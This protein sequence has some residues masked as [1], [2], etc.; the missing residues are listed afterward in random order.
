MQMMETIGLYN[1][2]KA[3]DAILGSPI[4]PFPSVST[5]EMFYTVEKPFTPAMSAAQTTGPDKRKEQMLH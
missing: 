3:R 5:R 2:R 1:I 4:I